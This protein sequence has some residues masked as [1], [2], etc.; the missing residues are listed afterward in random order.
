MVIKTQECAGDQ[1]A[2]VSGERSH[3]HRQVQKE[4]PE[5]RRRWWRTSSFNVAHKMLS[6]MASSCPPGMSPLRTTEMTPGHTCTRTP[7]KRSKDTKIHG[8]DE[9]VNTRSVDHQFHAHVVNWGKYLLATARFEGKV[10]VLVCL[11]QTLL[12]RT[13]SERVQAR[14]H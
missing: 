7:T 4:K 14:H 6:C 12:L 8:A 11:E 3:S 1:K 9:R 5:R 2:T 13:V 10:Q